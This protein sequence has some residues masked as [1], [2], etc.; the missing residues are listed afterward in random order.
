MIDIVVRGALGLGLLA[1]GLLAFAQEMGI[2]GLTRKNPSPAERGC[3]CHGL[4]PSSNVVVS[5]LGP[6]TLAVNQTGT[7]SV[8][9]SGGPA[10]RGG[11]NIAAS[12]GTLAPLA[13]SQNLQLFQGELTHKQPETFLSSG[14]VSF[15]FS[16][17]APASPGTQTVFANGNSTNGNGN[18]IGDEWNF[19]PDKTIVV[20][21]N[22]P[23]TVSDHPLRP[24]RFL[25][26]QN[27]PNPFNPSTVVDY[28]VPVQ[29]HVLLQVFDLTGRE[30]ATL[31][32]H[33]QS[34]GR[35]QARFVPSP[36]LSSAT[37]LYRLTAGSFSDQRKMALV[38]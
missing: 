26:H 8:V 32:D 22:P 29:S 31:V 24:E 33:E 13:P 23:T 34:P 12:A 16:Y 1:Y 17:T 20:I 10:V 18:A 4:S 38:R 27:Y 2:T 19:A 15:Q 37:Y 30:V 5:I 7:Y 36:Q 3:T 6:E 14:E 11:T 9:I 35:Y 21:E 28:E 25:L